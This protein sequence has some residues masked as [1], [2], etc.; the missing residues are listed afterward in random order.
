MTCLRNAAKTGHLGAFKY[1]LG[2]IKPAN[3]S[4]TDNL[5]NNVLHIAA[6]SGSVDIVKLIL[7]KDQL[8]I[9]SKNKDCCTPLQVA[10]LS[11]HPE[12]VKLLVEK[13]A[14]VNVQNSSRETP[15][16]SATKRG[17]YDVVNCLVGETN[18]ALLNKYQQTPLHEAAC[19]G[20]AE[21]VKLLLLKGFEVNASD[22]I[23]MTPFQY[24]A[25]GGFVNILQ[26]MLDKE[27]E[28]T[29]NTNRSCINFTPNRGLDA[30]YISVHKNN[31]EV[32]KFLVTHG[33]KINAKNEKY[34]STPLHEACWKGN[35]DIVKYLVDQGADVTIKE[36]E[37]NTPIGFA[38]REGHLEVV[39]YLLTNEKQMIDKWNSRIKPS[40][41]ADN[42]GKTP[43]MW[44]AARGKIDV[45]K[46]LIS[47]GA[48]FLSKNSQGQTAADLAQNE[49]HDKVVKYLQQIIGI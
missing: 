4:A 34:E 16:Y 7:E 26:I 9:E 13:G 25:K 6:S 27:T 3:L 41:D 38:S 47:D 46:A 29:K 11:N 44:A 14:I 32:A 28:E 20:H 35:I 17:A 12:V 43:L 5:L 40:H 37:G 1:L 23:P 49:G 45:V 10:A 33:A 8:I 31:F 2:I 21:I 30:L 48:N 19:N 22:N 36:K 24:A 42:I 18:L 39:K 15:L